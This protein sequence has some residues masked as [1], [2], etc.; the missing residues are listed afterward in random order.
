VGA[1]VGFM[2]L[3][4]RRGVRAV[5]VDATANVILSCACVALM[6]AGILLV[7]L[8]NNHHLPAGFGWYLIGLYALYVVASVVLVL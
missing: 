1:A 2:R 8:A 6:C 4:A 3:L 7:G 5:Q